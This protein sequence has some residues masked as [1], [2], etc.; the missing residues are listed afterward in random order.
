MFAN[1]DAS[2]KMPLIASDI[3]RI[4]ATISHYHKAILSTQILFGLARA[5]F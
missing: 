4:A 2:G 1:S 3:E 5:F